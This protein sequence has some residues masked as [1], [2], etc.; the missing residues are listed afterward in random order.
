MAKTGQSSDDQIRALVAL[1]ALRS[2]GDTKVSRLFKARNGRGL[3]P[4]AG[5]LLEDFAALLNLP[6]DR[7]LQRIRGAVADAELN[8]SRAQAAGVLPLP[9][10]DEAY[11]ALLYEIPD[12]P[13]ILW[14]DG[15][16]AALAA[17]SVAVV[18]SRNATPGGITTS[19]RLARDLAAAGLTVISGLARGI[20]AAA[21]RGALE[22]RGPTI[23]VLGNGA[24]DVYP[25]EHVALARDVIAGGGAIVTEF[26]PGTPPYASHFPLRNRIISGLSQAVVVVEA[27]ERSGSLITAKAALEQGRDVLAVP[28]AV[29]SGCYRG[30]HAL[31]KDG[32]RLVETVDD[33]LDEVGWAPRIA[34]Q[35]N[36]V[37]NPGE[38]GWLERHLTS[39][40]ALTLDD[41]AARTGKTAPHLLAALGQLELAGRVAR[42]PG[43]AFMKLD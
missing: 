7:R 14:I 40:E 22:G 39:G 28:G 19:R 23:A 31:I 5:H 6:V 42:L 12:P 38:G 2:G 10:T 27:S 4:P 33:I 20:D 43:G 15:P 18:G 1:A 41:L 35:D 36:L 30:C 34:H 3:L 32:A 9:I 29:A 25:R 13:L 17:P 37:P 11:P 24:G 8:L 26:P 21:H 16:V